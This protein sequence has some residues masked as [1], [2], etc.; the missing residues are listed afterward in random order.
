[1]K[2]EYKIDINIYSKDKL[3]QAVIDFKDV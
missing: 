3:E 2:K 1:M